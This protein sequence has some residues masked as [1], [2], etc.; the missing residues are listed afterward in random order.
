MSI[1]IQLLLSILFSLISTVIVSIINF[2]LAVILYNNVSESEITF[3]KNVLSTLYSKY[4]FKN[5]PT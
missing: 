3:K 1:L 4:I 5:E 2:I